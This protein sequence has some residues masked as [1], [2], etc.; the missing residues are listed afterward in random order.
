MGSERLIHVVAFPGWVIGVTQHR[1]GYRCWVITPEQVVLHDR[2]IYDS[3]EVAIA[4][5]RTLVELSID[6]TNDQGE[7]RQTDF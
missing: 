5:G 1:T 3:A 4:A 7:P 6:S 2:E